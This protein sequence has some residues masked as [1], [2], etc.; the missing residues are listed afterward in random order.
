MN[1]FVLYA[2]VSLFS[3]GG[4]MGGGNNPMVLSIEEISELRSRIRSALASGRLNAWQ[5]RF[6]TD[7]QQRLETYGPQVRLSVKQL[8]KLREI[9]GTGTSPGRVVQPSHPSRS[10]RRRG[11][12]GLLAR[13]G[14]W[15]GCHTV[16]GAIAGALKKKLGL[17]VT[18]DKV[19]GRGHVYRI[20]A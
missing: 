4:D 12:G 1:S 19:E 11:G 15:F 2:I 16:R 5:A 13:E 9:V 18:S 7:M 6:L 17:K 3:P 10:R 20:E 14:R 8:S